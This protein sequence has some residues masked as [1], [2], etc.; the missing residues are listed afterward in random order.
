MTGPP[1]PYSL[2][3][4]VLVE[5]PEALP[6]QCEQAWDEGFQG[7]KNGSIQRWLDRW[8][9]F[10]ETEGE[11]A[12]AEVCRVYSKHN[13]DLRGQ[14]HFKSAEAQLALFE[15]FLRFLGGETPQLAVQPD[16]FDL[17]E[18]ILTE[19]GQTELELNHVGKRGL[20]SGQITTDTAWLTI[21]ETKNVSADHIFTGQQSLYLSLTP[22]GTFTDQS[23][24]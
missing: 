9:K 15:Q 19:T 22:R 4:T 6:A 16:I 24:G 21:G 8:E 5:S 20:I 1:T 7:F 10:Y 23:D 14:L 12:R 18:I 3:E 2:T 11:T 17:D 13:V